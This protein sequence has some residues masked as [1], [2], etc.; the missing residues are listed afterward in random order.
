[1]SGSAL[2]FRKH[3]PMHVRNHRLGI[4]DGHASICDGCVC[5]CDSHM[6]ICDSCAG[7]CDGHAGIDRQL[8]LEE[9]GKF[10]DTKQSKLNAR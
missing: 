2:L 4:R 1:M 5:I 7:I 3:L 9:V 8:G 10:V 6:G